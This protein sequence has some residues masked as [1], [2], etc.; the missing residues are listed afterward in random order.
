MCVAN[1]EEREKAYI[2]NALSVLKSECE[3][4]YIAPRLFDNLGLE[5]ICGFQSQ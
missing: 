2:A 4:V 1:P 5:D 3:E